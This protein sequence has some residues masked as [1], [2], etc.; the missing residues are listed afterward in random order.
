M[1]IF[2]GSTVEDL[3]A[4]WNGGWDA[5]ECSSVSHQDAKAIWRAANDL[6]HLKKA[7][8]EVFSAAEQA[9]VNLLAPAL[10]RLAEKVR[11]YEPVNYAFNV[12]DYGAVPHRQNGLN[13]GHPAGR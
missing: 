4:A 12:E 7:Y 5:R 2:D 6:D 11:R 8:P 13:T 9:A 3:E 10:R 1:R